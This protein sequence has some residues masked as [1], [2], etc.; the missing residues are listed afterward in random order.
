MF[1]GK[2]RISRGLETKLQSTIKSSREGV[3]WRGNR[4]GGIDDDWLG[5]G[6]GDLINVGGG[7]D[8][9]HFSSIST[10]IKEEEACN[11]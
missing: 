5:S 9:G 7:D 6:G 1:T 4:R 2:S 11:V 10:K 3:A 8:G